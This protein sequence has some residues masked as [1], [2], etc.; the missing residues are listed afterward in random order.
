MRLDLVRH[1]HRQ[2]AAS[3]RNFG[4]DTGDARLLGVVKHIEKEL[5]EIRQEPRDI[6]EWIDVII[7]GFD[8]AWRAGYTPEQIVSA[9]IAK[10]TLNES[11]QWPD[12][13]TAPAGEPIEHVRD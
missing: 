9:L 1:L 11:R 5:G 7:L 12:W 6:T 8:G 4:P 2:I 3:K 13:R 10:Q